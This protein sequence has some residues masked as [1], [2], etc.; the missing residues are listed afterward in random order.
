M[1][2]DGTFKSA[3]FTAAAKALKDSHNTSGGAPNTE[4]L[5]APVLQVELNCYHSYSILLFGDPFEKL[6]KCI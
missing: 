3:A 1:V 2:A 6:S 4:K 5:L